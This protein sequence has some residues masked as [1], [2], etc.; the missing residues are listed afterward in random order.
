MQRNSPGNIRQGEQGMKQNLSGNRKPKTQNQIMDVSLYF[1]HVNESTCINLF[2]KYL[3][4]RTSSTSFPTVYF[5][6][7]LLILYDSH[8]LLYKDQEMP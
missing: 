3:Q 5:S 1:D 8:F 6:Y 7:Y 2:N 4:E